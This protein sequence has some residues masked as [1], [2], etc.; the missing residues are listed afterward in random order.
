MFC[1]GSAGFWGKSQR[2]DICTEFDDVFFFQ[3][4]VAADSFLYHFQ[5][6]NLVWYS[7]F[8]TSHFLF[9]FV[10][11]FIS[12]IHQNPGQ[13]KDGIKKFLYFFRT[14]YY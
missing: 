12:S 11:K 13:K 10:K 8:V 5:W 1:N 7:I 3:I 9:F 4:V 6:K 2:I 14:G